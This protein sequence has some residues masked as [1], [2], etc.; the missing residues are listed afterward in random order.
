M[1]ML[2]LNLQPTA[3]QQGTTTMSKT[4]AWSSR[5]MCHKYV[6]YLLRSFQ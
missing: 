3:H 4:K 1:D 5:N 2:G 6:P